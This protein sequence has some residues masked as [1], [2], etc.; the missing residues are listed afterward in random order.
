MFERTPLYIDIGT[1]Q[2]KV[3]EKKGETISQIGIEP[4]P[5][6]AMQAG[7][8]HNALAVKKALLKL[9][10][11][12]GVRTWRRRTVVAL[13]GGA[14]II[15]RVQL[16]VGTDG[17]S[18][19]ETVHYE[20]EKYFQHDITDLYYDFYELP[21]PAE[22]PDVPVL[23][24]GAK[25]EIVDRYVEIIKSCGLRAAII[26]CEVFSLLNM[27]EYNY[28]KLEGLVC[29]ANIGASVTQVLFIENGNYLYMRDM[30]AGGDGFTQA[31]S[32]QL[33]IPFAQA[34]AVKIMS[35]EKP[36]SMHPRVAKILTETS[37][38]FS[39]DMMMTIDYFFKQ[40]DLPP[41]ADTLKYLF[42]IGGG[43]RINML[44]RVLNQALGVQV[45]IINPFL[46]LKVSR[47]QRSFAERNMGFFGV[48]GGLL[49]RNL[50]ELVL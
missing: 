30:P 8:I 7:I 16:T 1:S 40:T 27:L 10:K 3:A 34:E 43:S 20:A 48:L 32:Q 5:R 42:L 45:A 33:K 13:S 49:R 6:G 47:K 2:I 23:L 35:M 38:Q 37:Q 31:L 22:S 18:V 9:L 50:D 41:H 26:D 24:V 21:H 11:R 29:V 15:K 19:A 28:G 39:S 14:L 46:K 44:P 17:A 36:V 12:L 25:R 4:L